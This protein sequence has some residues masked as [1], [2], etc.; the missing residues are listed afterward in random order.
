M[1][2]HNL[3]HDEIAKAYAAFASDRVEPPSGADRIIIVLDLLLYRLADLNGSNGGRWG[4]VR[5]QGPGVLSG[6]GAGGV[7]VSI[8]NAL[9]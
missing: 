8:I 6:A 5:R 3:A 4:K 7:I 1:N 9:T 2:H